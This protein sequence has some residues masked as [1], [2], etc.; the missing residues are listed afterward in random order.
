MA[1]GEGG[2]QDPQLASDE[3]I[4]KRLHEEEEEGLRRAAEGEQNDEAIARQLAQLD[5]ESAGTAAPM[6]APAPEMEGDEE[7][8]R[9]LHD[10]EMRAQRAT[11]V[12][13]AQPVAPPL[14]HATVLPPLEHTHRFVADLEDVVGQIMS[15]LQARITEALH[16][17]HVRASAPAGAEADCAATVPLESEPM[18]VRPPP[19]SS[20][21]RTNMNTPHLGSAPPVYVTPVR[22]R[23]GALACDARGS[24]G[25][26]LQT[27]RS[28][29]RSRAHRSCRAFASG[30]VRRVLVCA[31]AG[32]RR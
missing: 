26:P 27:Q 1:S 16:E 14:A 5:L 9:Q 25:S 18:R 15:W 6:G 12:A 10:E 29:H 2:S 20:I 31:R 4:A 21:A 23:G 28:A 24:R 19:T 3:D 22:R 32:R 30:G 11:H 7:L 8:A 13:L 17:S